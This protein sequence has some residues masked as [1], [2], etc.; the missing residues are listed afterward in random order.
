MYGFNKVP[1]LSRGGH[2][3]ADSGMCIMELVS[4]INREPF[5]DHPDCTDTRVSAY[6]QNVNDTCT[7]AERTKLLSVLDRMF[8]TGDMTWEQRVDSNEGLRN[9]W[10]ELKGMVVT[11]R[12]KEMY[13][14]AMA[15][16]D[17]LIP[18]AP[19]IW[20]FLYRVSMGSES[21]DVKLALLNRVLDV[22]DEVMG[23][24]ETLPQNRAEIE[25]MLEGVQK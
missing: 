6:M 17:R 23:V 10:P 16:P 12:G 22:M 14:Q 18:T 15:K 3:S 9:I 11:D 2:G 1:V 25:K 20:D 19:R 13:A 7:D 24:E 8:H 4:F 5:S 21:V